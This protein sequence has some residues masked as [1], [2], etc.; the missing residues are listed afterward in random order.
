MQFSEEVK[1]T[2]WNLIDDIHVFKSI[3]I[4]GTSRKRFFYAD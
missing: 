4:H 2:L 3:K 1:S